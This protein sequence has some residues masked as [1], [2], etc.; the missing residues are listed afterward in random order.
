MAIHYIEYRDAE[1][2][3][4]HMTYLKNLPSRI[5]AF[6]VGLDL[7]PT[8]EYGKSREPALDEVLA[9]ALA[10]ST[11]WGFTSAELRALHHTTRSTLNTLL[12]HVKARPDSLSV[13][14]ATLQAQCAEFKN[15]QQECLKIAEVAIAVIP[16]LMDFMNTSICTYARVN[17]LIKGESKAEEP[18][19]LNRILTPD[20]NMTS[21]ISK[22]EWNDRSLCSTM[23][24]A[25][26]MGI[27]CGRLSDLLEATRCGLAALDAKQSPRSINTRAQLAVI[28]AREA[29]RLINHTFDNILRFRF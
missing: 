18:D 14:L 9:K 4:F 7:V 19:T 15:R 13:E 25:A 12:E 10:G 5:E 29:L 28:P 22:V 1:D 11:L 27:Y 26:N 17:N 20:E 24:S 16:R 2:L 21:A 3:G 23:L 6:K 8:D